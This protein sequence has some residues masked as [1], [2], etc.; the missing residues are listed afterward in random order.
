MIPENASG[1]RRDA[2]IGHELAHI[3]LGHSPRLTS[4][5]DGLAE[6]APSTPPELAARYLP[7]QGYEADIEQ[8]A[9]AF[10]TRLISH[11]QTHPALTTAT[12][13]GRLSNRLR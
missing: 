7:R 12:E 6:L 3:V 1:A 13:L 11:V 9:E 5:I 4:D 2:I 10:A 8:E